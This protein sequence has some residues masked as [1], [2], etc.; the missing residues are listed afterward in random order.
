MDDVLIRFRLVGDE[1]RALRELSVRELRSPRDQVRLILRKEL[2]RLGFLPQLNSSV[3][4][5]VPDVPS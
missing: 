5:K 3:Q 4:Q 1:A 2:E